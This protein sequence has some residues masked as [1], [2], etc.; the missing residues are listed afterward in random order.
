MSKV[1][2][3]QVYVF[4]CIHYNVNLVEEV[5]KCFRKI[6]KK[7]IFQVEKGSKGGK[8]HLQMFVNLKVK[9]R[10]GEFVKLC[11]AH[12]LGGIQATIA[13]DAG[14]EALKNYCLKEE[15]RVKGPWADHVIY[16]GQ[17]LPV[18][19]YPWQQR[20]VDI[21]D[22]PV[23][24]RIIYWIYDQHGNQ[25]KSKLAKYLMFHR[26]IMTLPAADAS[27]VLNLVFKTPS[28]NCYIFDIPRTI[29]K[30][31]SMDDLYAALES[32]KNGYIVNTKY[33][34]GVK[35]MSPPHVFVFSNRLPNY[36]SL[37]V[38]RWKIITLSQKIQENL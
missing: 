13:S 9:K 25:G 4:S 12:G 14:K 24:D 32:I 8:E 2:N 6:A 31:V 26:N 35:L 20:V 1:S 27:N 15:T 37:S 3:N 38:D 18:D 7:W 5:K 19:L 36:S 30:K 23:D 22:G 29:S 11:S 21:I 33:E 17:D 16:M 28:R 10:K 34:T